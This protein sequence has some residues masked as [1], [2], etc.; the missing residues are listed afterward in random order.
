MLKV[1]LAGNGALEAIKVDT[2]VEGLHS[3][4][5]VGECVEFENLAVEGANVLH[6]EP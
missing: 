6:F 1:I 4:T 2:G 5:I 3:L